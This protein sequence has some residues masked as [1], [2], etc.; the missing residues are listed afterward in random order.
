MEYKKCPKCELNY[1][2]ENEDL[3]PECKQTIKPAQSQSIVTRYYSRLERGRIYGT[4][5]RTIYETGC[6]CFGWDRS[7]ANQFGRQGVPLYAA[8]ATPEKYSVWFI[9][10]SNWTATQGGEWANVISRDMDTIKEYWRDYAAV[11]TSDYITRVVFA[12]KDGNYC[13]L[14]IYEPEPEFQKE[15]WDGET[16]YVKIYYCI[17]EVYPI[18]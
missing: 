9:S 17:S 15:I 5:S 11:K 14:G 13:F 1:I 3:C 12:K 8:S 2:P 16:H 4:N 7:K 10:H 6:D 18:K